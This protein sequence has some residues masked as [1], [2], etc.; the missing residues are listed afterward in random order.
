ML[1]AAPERHRNE[2]RRAL[3][4]SV[5]AGAD[6]FRYRLKRWGQPNRKASTSAH[7]CAWYSVRGARSAGSVGTAWITMHVFGAGYFYV[8]LYIYF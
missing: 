6:V 1:E 5:S 8:F 2:E 3:L 4:L 7:P